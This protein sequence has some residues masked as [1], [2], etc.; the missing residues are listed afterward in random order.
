MI[1]ADR[2]DELDV[3]VREHDV[4]RRPQRECRSDPDAARSAN[5]RSPRSDA[6]TPTGCSPRRTA[7]AR[8]RARRSCPARS[9]VGKPYIRYACTMMPA[10]VNARVTRATC[11]TVT[12]FFMRSSS[13]SD[14]TS[15]PPLT[16]TQPDSASSAQSS[17]VNVFSK[18]M[19]PH[20]V[21]A[22]LLGDEALRERAQPGRRRGLV[23][24][25]E[26]GLA[27]LRDQR[28]N[29]L[30]DDVG[31]RPVVAADVVERHV[32]ERALLPVAAVRERDLVPAAVGPEAMHRIQHL[33]HRDVVA[34]RQ[35][36]VGREC[37][38]RGSGCRAAWRP[39][40]ARPRRP[41]RT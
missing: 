23:D 4:R 26:A 28:A 9:R 17:G 36:V 7:G 33:E 16:A 2:I 34:E 39:S 37:R 19:L 1:R 35:A 6:S 13:R 30:H 31:A 25:M 24:E 41:R 15:R 11:S 5:A 32:A 14:A 10:S 8:A 22:S 21:I 27:G 29:S 40:R 3:V 20:H 18:R 12:P 38:C